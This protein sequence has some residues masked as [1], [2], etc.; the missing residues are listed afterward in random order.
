M[1][2]LD[3]LPIL[4]TRTSLR[5]GDKYAT[6]HSNQVVVWVSVHLEGVLEPEENIPRFPTAVG[7]SGDPPCWTRE[8]TSTSQCKTGNCA[9]GP[10]STLDCW[11]S[12]GTSRSMGRWSSGGRRRFGYIRTSPADRM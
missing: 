6:I 5:F 2:I 3:R 9:S 12:L 1:K 11:R 7:H 8:T 4:A 10:G